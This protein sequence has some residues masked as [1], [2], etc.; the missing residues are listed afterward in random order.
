MPRRKIILLAAAGVIALI[1][2]LV[3]RSMMQPVE[4]PVAQQQIPTTEV[5]A[6]ARDLSTGTIL[7]ETDLKWV[8][9]PAE[10][11][12][13]KLY[14]KGKVEMNSVA[15]AVLREGLRADEPLLMG[16]VVQPHEQGFLA[17]V[18]TPGMRAVSVTLTPSGEVAGFIFPGDRVDVILTHRFVIKNE[19]GENEAAER[20]LSETVVNDVRVLAL[21]Q[22]SDSQST[23]PKIAQLATLEVTPKQAEELALA[24]DMAGAANANHG[25]ISLV[26]RSLA[27]ENAQT[28][29]PE[30]ETGKA[31]G[32]TMDSDVSPVFP[33]VAPMRKVHIM[34]GNAVTDYVFQSPK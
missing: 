5:L 21:D 29:T 3:A 20:A 28:S 27:N 23:D 31:N 17:A 16:R 34:R 24:V 9:W 6:A 12:T 10:A 33:R 7:K 13:S 11:E 18:L 19:K 32:P 4:T 14:V 1:T 22:K 30:A 15:G 26:L 25:S 2:V 8:P